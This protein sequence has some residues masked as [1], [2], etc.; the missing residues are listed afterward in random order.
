MQ[1]EEEDLNEPLD[2]LLDGGRLDGEVIPWT[3]QSAVPDV[4]RLE[5]LDESRPNRVEMYGLL[6]SWDAYTDDAGNDKNG[7]CYFTAINETVYESIK[8]SHKHY[9]EIQEILRKQKEEQ[10]Q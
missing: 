3:A 10:D 2:L 9:D 1:D 4:I 8:N 7:G 6:D 5:W